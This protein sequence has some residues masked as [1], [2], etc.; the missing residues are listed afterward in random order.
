MRGS[1]HDIGVGNKICGHDPEFT[2]KKSIATYDIPS[3]MAG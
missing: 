3:N 1:P 2:Q